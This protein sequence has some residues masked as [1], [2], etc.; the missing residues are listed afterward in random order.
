MVPTTGKRDQGGARVKVILRSVG[1]RVP[2]GC[3]VPGVLAEPSCSSLLVVQTPGFLS[4]LP[5]PLS[6]SISIRNLA[7]QIDIQTAP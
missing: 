5:L 6:L 2:T 1:R 7:E 4:Y 3:G